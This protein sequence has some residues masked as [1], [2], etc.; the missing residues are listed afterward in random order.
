M[1]ITRNH[2]FEVCQELNIR[3]I[4][5]SIHIEDLEKIDGAFMTGTSVNVLPISS[6]DEISLDSVNN[7]IIRSIN[8]AYSRKMENY[9]IDNKNK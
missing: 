9:I 4:E 8:N 1:G 7:E 6:I 3:V 2:I 5:E